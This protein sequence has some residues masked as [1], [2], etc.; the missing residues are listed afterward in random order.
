MTRLSF[1]Y[2]IRSVYAGECFDGFS[3]VN[4]LTR[5]MSCMYSVE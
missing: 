5:H 2:G 1:F 3:I 4:R